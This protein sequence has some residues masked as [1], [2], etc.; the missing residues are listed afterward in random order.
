M[1]VRFCAGI[2]DATTSTGLAG[3]GPGG[4]GGGGAVCL[5]PKTGSNLFT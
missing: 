3:G 1:G 4:R 5:G 2:G